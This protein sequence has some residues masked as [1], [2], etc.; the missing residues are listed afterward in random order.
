M[1]EKVDLRQSIDRKTY[2]QEMKKLEPRLNELQQ[3]CRDYGIPVVLVL[4]GWSAAGKGTLTGKIT[5]PLDPRYFNVYTTK[6]SE[7]NVMRPTLYSYWVKMPSEGRMAIFDKSWH[8]AILPEGK[9]AWNMS[10]T[11]VRGYCYDV[12][13][14]EDKL[15]HAGVLMIKLFLHISKA[16]QK[17][18]FNVLE[19][20][21]ATRWRIDEEDWKQNKEYAKYLSYFEEMIQKTDTEANAWNIIEAVDAKFATVKIFKTIISKIEEKIKQRAQ[22]ERAVKSDYDYEEKDVPILRSIDLNQTVSPKVYK[23]KLAEYQEWIAYLGNKL[24][25]NRKSLVIVYEGWDAAGKGGNIKRLTAKL[26]PRGYEVIPIAAPTKE[27]LSHDYL[28]RF[29]KKMPKDGHIGIF[30]RSWYG[31]IMVERVEGFCS[32]EEWKRAY[33]E[34][35]DMELHMA[36]H[37]TI[38]LKFWLHIDKKEQ[39]RRFQDRQDDPLK[40]YKITEED[41]RNREKW[42]VYET[43]VDE[44]L[45]RTNTEYAPWIIVESNNKK[46]AR[47]KVMKMVCEELERRLEM[48]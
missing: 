18:R 20:D 42:D 40:Q 7:E 30:D 9:V 45:F 32:E 44:M 17:K 15:S 3:K 34:I 23:K 6:P 33:A 2:K 28:W 41:W 8:R 14:F 11:A 25:T 4:E 5:Y 19:K 39:L 48:G 1:L 22:A 16:E 47:L 37:G 10:E 27:E 26:D 46:F 24:Y 21:P 31:R 13:A 29:W 35:N 38:V 43:A 36:N 12:N